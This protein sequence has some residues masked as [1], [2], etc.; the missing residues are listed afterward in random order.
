M[1]WNGNQYA[2]RGEE[3]V[4][5]S[6]VQGE[7][8]DEVETRRSEEENTQIK[9]ET[10][11]QKI[12]MRLKGVA[13]QQ[14][15]S[16]AQKTNGVNKKDQTKHQEYGWNNKGQVYKKLISKKGI[17]QNLQISTKYS[18]KIIY[19]NIIIIIFLLITLSILLFI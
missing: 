4:S 5:E 7:V 16:N 14:E 6:S 17:R 11:T 19:I 8:E 3:I 1:G 2:N 12:N 10:K 9:G 13:C 15:T 18:F